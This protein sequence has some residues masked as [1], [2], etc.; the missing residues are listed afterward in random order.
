LEKRI[1]F[2]AH[3]SNTYGA[4]QSLL[5]MVSV[6]KSNEIYFL[7]VVPSKG[8]IC[9]YF[10]EFGYNYSVVNYKSE[11][12][13]SSA[14]FL[15]KFKNKVSLLR[16]NIINYFAL[17]KLNTLVLS[18][19]I[20]VIHSNSAIVKIG[21]D[22]AKY[23]K[24]RHIWHLRELIHPN[25]NLFVFGGLDKYKK[26]IRHSDKII[27]VSKSVAESYN[28]IQKCFIL[29]DAVR[30]NP[31]YKSP[32]EK[33]KYFL[34]C[35]TLHKNKGIEEAIM[36]F[37][38]V[39]LIN[40]SYKLLLVGSG[41]ANYVTFLKNKV[42]NI[43]LKNN[44]VFLGFRN[45]IDC[46][47]ARANAFLMCSRNEALGRVT[48]EAMLNFCLVFGYNDTGTSEIIE[49][50]STGF[51]YNEKSELVSLM[52][53]SIENISSFNNIVNKAYMFASSNFL[54]KDYGI[55]LIEF[56]KK[57]DVK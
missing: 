15:L 33:E 55:K 10:D 18:N 12:C 19:N 7:I 36:A 28:V 31:K 17:K 39:F 49:H 38:D 3:D 46:L 52:N 2:I 23:N 27:C 47:M 32:I 6:L 37:Y 40:K 5:N 11:L 26:I 14:N 25:Y 45:D 56:Y 41:D 13:N 1:L 48:I 4:N 8:E 20:N 16:K 35:G 34:F 29:K 43:G 53:K 50:E 30:K 21:F 57:T 9:S 54:E 44:V 24:I 22:L 51:L 42:F